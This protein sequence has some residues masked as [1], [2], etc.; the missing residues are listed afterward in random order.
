MHGDNE[1]GWDDVVALCI[2]RTWFW[3]GTAATS[4]LIYGHFLSTLNP[5][6][7]DLRSQRVWNFLQVSIFTSPER[8]V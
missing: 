1:H 8:P 2:A 4:G 5:N 3:E 7:A 6:T